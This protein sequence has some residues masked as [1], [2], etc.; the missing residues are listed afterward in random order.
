VRAWVCGEGI[1]PVFAAHAAT[2]SC[3]HS[4]ICRYTSMAGLAAPPRGDTLVLRDH[5][6]THT[7]ARS[8]YHG[9]HH[10]LACHKHLEGRVCS[11][12]PMQV[13]GASGRAEELSACVNAVRGIQV[14]QWVVRW[15]HSCAGR[16]RDLLPPG[17]CGTSSVGGRPVCATYSAAWTS[18]PVRCAPDR[19]A[20]RGQWGRWWL[21]GAAGGGRENFARWDVPCLDFLLAETGPED[22]SERIELGVRPRSHPCPARVLAGM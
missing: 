3:I 17:A 15:C 18:T 1:W 5:T 10:P 11:T 2:S 21:P 14:L 8:L 4:L 7:H 9:S 16:S 12:A 13:L 19:P 6:H 22:H 20:S